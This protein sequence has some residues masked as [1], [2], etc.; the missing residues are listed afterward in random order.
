MRLPGHVAHYH[1]TNVKVVL[2]EVLQEVFMEPRGEHVNVPGIVKWG[3]DVSYKLNPLR[4]RGDNS[5][6]GKKLT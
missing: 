3:D 5:E 6:K 1:D 2:V 4:V